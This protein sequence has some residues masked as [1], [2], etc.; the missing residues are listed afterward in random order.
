MYKRQIYGTRA[1]SGVILITTK[2]GS[3]TNGKIKLT[4]HNEFTHRV[5]YGKP[6]ML[7]GREYV[8]HRIG[9]DYGTDTDWWDELLSKDNFSQ[10]HHVALNIG[11]EKVKM[12]T[13]FF[14]EKQEGV[15]IGDG[16]QDYGGRIN[17]EF[18]LF[19]DWFVIRPSA[20]YRQTARDNRIPY[21]RQAMAN[22]PTRSPYDANSPTGYNVWTNESLDYNVLADSKLYDYYGLDKW[23]KPEVNLKLD[24]KAIP[25]LSYDQIIGYENRQWENHA[26]RT[27]YHRD[28]LEESRNGSAYLGFSKIEN[29]L[30][31]TSDAAD[32]L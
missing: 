1:A 15:A 22:N 7:T 25:G 14:Y 21:F 18:K 13:S 8:A 16:R 9:T 2:S 29:C 19:D 3:D 28:E 32:E 12:Y 6:K 10:R 30:L 4:Y 11:T 20:D 31:Y 17:A 23:F 26:Y 5:A 24:I 27:R